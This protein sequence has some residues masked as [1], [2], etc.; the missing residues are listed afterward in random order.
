M[1][2]DQRVIWM[3]MP[4]GEGDMIEKALK[5]QPDVIIPCVEDG[6]P[7]N[8][9]S[10]AAARAVLL[11]KLGGSTFT[12]HDVLVYPRVNHP[13]G[14]YWKD[15][16]DTV[17][18]TEASGIVIP[19]TESAQDVLDVAAY[20][21]G[22]ESE[23]GREIGSTRIIAMIETPKGVLRAEAIAG[24]H[25][26]VRGVL[27]GREDFSAAVGLMRR[28]EDSLREGSPE[29]LFARSAVVAAAQAVGV[30][31]IDGAAFTLNDMEYINKD[32]SL[33]A[34]LGY[35]GKLAAHPNHVKGIRF[36]FTPTDEDLE[37]A[38]LMVAVESESD[39]SGEAAVA[40]VAGMEVTPPVVA[41]A[42][43]LLKRSEWAE[44]NAGRGR[45]AAK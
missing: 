40:G 5:Y 41:Q 6:V 19:K 28:H 30:E 10:K 4:G 26:R 16:I 2:E 27:F 21:D 20:L 32:A 31:A 44:Q 11:E 29:L 8:E 9:D 36:G 18:R 38:K 22:A 39:A 23:A 42:K 15:D 45:K 43:L 24:A 3:M 25:K 17:M 12:E 34:R 13:T 33:T 14:P 35:T 37:L 1:S 7:Y